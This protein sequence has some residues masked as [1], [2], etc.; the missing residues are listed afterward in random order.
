MYDRSKRTIYR[1]TIVIPPNELYSI[2]QLDDS[3]TDFYQREPLSKLFCLS[4]NVEKE[5]MLPYNKK[6]TK[7]R[8]EKSMEFIA[9]NRSVPKSTSVTSKAS[10]GDRISHELIEL[11]ELEDNRTGALDFRS[12]VCQV[13]HHP[14]GAELSHASAFPSFVAFPLPLSCPPLS[15]S[16]R[17]RIPFSRVYFFSL[18]LFRPVPGP[19]PLSLSM[20]CFEIRRPR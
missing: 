12:P 13:E 19:F 17:L 8:G 6:K 2:D 20:V 5:R 7:K 4:P 10:P 18:S 15:G 9:E 3:Q 1:V 16:L 11:A 14:D